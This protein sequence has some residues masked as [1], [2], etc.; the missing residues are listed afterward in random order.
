MDKPKKKRGFAAMSPE[1]RK[2]IAARGGTA[3]RP[4]QR[5]FAAVPGLAASAG[6]KARNRGSSTDPTDA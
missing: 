4:E 3:L 1:K 6:A 5:G 2:A